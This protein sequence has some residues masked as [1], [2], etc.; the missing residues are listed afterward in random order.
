MIKFPDANTLKRV[1][2]EKTQRAE[3]LGIAIFPNSYKVCKVLKQILQLDVNDFK[4]FL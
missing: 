2:L 4:G 1:I 3:C